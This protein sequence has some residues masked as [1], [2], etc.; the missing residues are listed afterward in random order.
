M[1]DQTRKYLIKYMKKTGRQRTLEVLKRTSPQK[2][3]DKRRAPLKLSFQ[4]LKAPERKASVEEK[5]P[6][7]KRGKNSNGIGLDDHEKK[8]KAEIPDDFKKIVSKFGLPEEHID[9][10]YEYRDK[11]VW[12]IKEKKKV[13]CTAQGCNFSAPSSPNSL[14]QHMAEVHDYGEYPCSK[15][16]CKFVAYAK[17]CLRKHETQFHGTGRRRRLTHEEFACQ[18]CE[19]TTIRRLLLDVHMRIHEN[20]QIKCE[21]CSYTAVTMKQIHDHILY[22]FRIKNFFC[23]ICPAS[24]H[25]NGI[26]TQHLRMHSKDYACTHCMNV[27]ATK[28]QFD[29][30]VRECDVRLSKFI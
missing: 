24:F 21:F 23:P 20:L 3:K 6:K 1:D 27:F 26:L 22:H 8:K 19:F 7:K 2:Q 28:N 9:F 30:H 14:V 29:R 18:L 5:Q 15:E 12:E 13:F 10:F 4:I 16:D 11:F 25:I 17:V